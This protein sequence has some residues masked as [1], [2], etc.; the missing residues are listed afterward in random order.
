[1]ACAA[2]AQSWSGFHLGTPS[3]HDV[4]NF[5]RHQRDEA[6]AFK[7]PLSSM[8]VGLHLAILCCSRMFAYTSVRRSQEHQSLSS[9]SCI[10]DASSEHKLYGQAPSAN[11][12]QHRLCSVGDAAAV[13]PLC[14]MLEFLLVYLMST[15]SGFGLLA[16][17]CSL[18]P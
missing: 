16:A 8:R 6:L 15:G 14:M 7:K 12:L 3:A 11:S 5:H 1:M 13:N 9:G 17:S 2:S 4:L 18:E 10:F